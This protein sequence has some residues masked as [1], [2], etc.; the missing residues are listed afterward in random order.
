[1]K[2]CFFFFLILVTHLSTISQ[3]HVWK[4]EP[5]NWWIDMPQRNLQLM[6][7]GDE[8]GKRKPV[9]NHESVKIERYSTDNN[10]N[11]L[12]LDLKIGDADQA[13]SFEI[14]FYLEEELIDKITYDLK[15]RTNNKYSDQKLSSSDA[16]YLINADRFVNGNI[17]NDRIKDLNEN[18]LNRNKYESRHGGD[19][20]GVLS[21]LNYI[22]KMGFTA[23]CMSSLL[24][25]DV[26]ENSYLG[27]SCTDMYNIDPR[28]GSNELYKKL[29]FQCREKGVKLFKDVALNH[30]SN[31]HWWLS[32][33][34]TNKWIN[35]QNDFKVS[36]K[37]VES[38]F[39]PYMSKSDAYSRTKSW[40]K[41]DKP[42]LNQSNKFL[43][44]YLIQ[45]AVW[46]VEYAGLSGLRVPYFS[47]LDKG[48]FNK[49]VLEVHKF[50]PNISIVADGDLYDKSSFGLIQKGNNEEEIN[51]IPVLMDF[52]LQNSIIKSFHPKKSLDDKKLIF[53][54]ENL[55]NDY[56][57]S[58]PN[59]MI[60]FLD[61]NVLKRSYSQLGHDLEYWKMAF[62]Y[63]LVTRGIPQI[64][65]GSEILLSDSLGPG[66]VSGQNL[67]FPGGWRSDKVNGFNTDGLTI[68]QKEAQLF[69][70][71]ILNWRKGNEVLSNGRLIHFAPSI[72]DELYCLVRY[73]KEK[74]VLLFLNNNMQKKWISLQGYINQIPSRVKSG[75]AVN[76]LSEM[77]IDVKEKQ[78]INKK[79]FLL[80]EYFF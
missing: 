2:H 33:L 26:E 38:L 40:V 57:Y 32:D 13:I 59:S 67:D 36:N 12:F 23:I 69:L 30:V 29:S 8:I 45:N 20:Q 56:L 25:N 19:I 18:K 9:I 75:I 21:Q 15:E 64:Y 76:V 61:N 47:H 70:K 17:N 1:M 74:M 77:E 4:I 7:Y 66:K 6:I 51:D 14:E 63:L 37:G 60:V 42:D 28:F 22:E 71:K 43:S 35:N 72:E 68:E 52:P 62:S 78:L 73:N 46:W 44:K 16:I 55:V 41:E 65:Y 48:Y 80:V 11:Y 79:S 5:P 34:P 39:D 54:Y 53:L 3:S 10:I 27:L 49:W 24:F 31:E 50:H 58:D